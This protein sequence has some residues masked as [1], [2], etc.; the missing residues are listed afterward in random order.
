MIYYSIYG[1]IGA[2]ERKAL[3]KLAIEKY[4]ETGRPLRI[5]IDV[6]IW[7]F[8]IQ[9]GRGGSDPAIRTL[10]YRLLRLLSLCIQP[11]FV[12]DGPN[13]PPFKRNK[14]TGSGGGLVSNML[15]KQLIKYFNFPYHEAPGE[16]EAECALLQQNGIVDAV[17]SEDVDTLM[18]GSN[19]CLRNWSSEG[20]RGNKAPTHVSIYS[21]KAIL[22]KY[23][24]DREG[25]ILV[26]L[27]SGGDYDTEGIPGCGIK[28]A[29]EAA[30]AGFGKSLCAI[31]QKDNSGYKS[32]RETLAREI[33][34]N[35]G[36]FFKTK[37]KTLQIPENFPD[38][39]IL[40][41]Y[42]HPVVSCMPKILKL[43]EEIQWSGE[44]DVQGLRRF[45]AEAFDWTHKSGALKF[46]RGLAPALLAHK[47]RL[48]GE[49]EDSEYHDV[50]LTAMNE[51]ELV[52]AIVG[53]RENFSTDG[54]PEL[55]L[56]Y[57][58]IDIVRLDLDAEEES[59]KNFDRDGL[60]PRNA[61]DQIEEFISNDNKSENK[62][63]LNISLYDPTQP[64]KVWVARTIAR[65]GVPLK[66]EDYEE[67]L[68]N[69]E[70][71]L[72]AKA[73]AK[74]SMTK[75]NKTS[76]NESG[77]QSL[78]KL[79]GVCQS[80]PQA[81]LGKSALLGNS[82]SHG[83][84]IANTDNGLQNS[85]AQLKSTRMLSKKSTTLG[86]EKTTSLGS[87]GTAMNLKLR[88]QT[89]KKASSKT[90]SPRPALMNNN[91]LSFNKITKLCTQ[92]KGEKNK[93]NDYL[94]VSKTFIDLDKCHSPFKNYSHSNAS[95][96][97]RTTNDQANE[98]SVSFCEPHGK[99]VSKCVI[100]HM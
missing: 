69:P 94:Q 23:G 17:M 8:Q 88:T 41:Y 74:K 57:H 92:K 66:V 24:L 46:I 78:P 12:F 91:E 75:K 99:L 100:S 5:A 6:A 10:Y 32:W 70:K 73:A 71:F 3:Y 72:K 60:A 31:S 81:R 34:T 85:S 54:I 28:L 18:F 49:I 14:R 61:E 11:L 25:M 79:T 56:V 4:E 13:K 95:A 9:A 83:Y 98:M 48:N 93:V 58:P 45:V 37:R 55:R 7:Q 2:G 59:S 38:R 76:K 64:D 36:K 97:S 96:S 65:I 62:T 30:K 29:C 33:V 52:R 77:H 44:V 89:G 82:S 86:A 27:M 63:N 1:E 15:T 26:A 51:N 67:S 47:L 16:A 80:L 21:K 42:T 90:T 39:E 22:E 68:R 20:Q 84:K 53:R 43:K 19:L 35:N 40:G 87:K 50:I